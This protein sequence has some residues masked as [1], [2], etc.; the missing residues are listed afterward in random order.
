MYIRFGGEDSE[1]WH[2]DK[3][4][5]TVL[6][7]LSMVSAKYQL[8]RKELATRETF[9]QDIRTLT[10]YFCFSGWGRMLDFMITQ[11]ELVP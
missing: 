9:F 1:T 4:R 6:F 7:L 5:R 10:Y 2:G 11:L 8:L 3:L